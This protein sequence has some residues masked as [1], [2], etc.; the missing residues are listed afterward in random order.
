MG[1]GE[2]MGK[3]VV[4]ADIDVLFV[5]EVVNTA[6]FLF[7][8]ILDILEVEVALKLSIDLLASQLQLLPIVKSLYWLRLHPS[9]ALGELLSWPDW[10]MC[11]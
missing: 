11:L 10:S 5:A 2:R 8:P 6:H 4:A 7:L 9:Q 3:T 1:M